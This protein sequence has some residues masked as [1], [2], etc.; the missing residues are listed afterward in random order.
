V[1]AD[2]DF[3]TG[4]RGVNL[5][6][7]DP[8]VAAALDVI[9]VALAAGG[10]H[11]GPLP[12]LAAATTCATV[13][14]RWRAPATMVIVA[15][16]SSAVF[17]VSSHGGYQE[18]AQVALLLDYYALGRLASQRGQPGVDV[19]LLAVPLAIVVAWGWNISRETGVGLWA[20]GTAVPYAVGR[21]VTS[22]AALS[23]QLQATARRLEREQQER[24]R[25][26]AA[27]ERNRIARELHD[28]VA[29]NVSVMV[30]QT[31]AAR[32]LAGRDRCSVGRAVLG[33]LLRSRRADGDAAD[34]WRAP[35]WRRGT[36]RGDG[37]RAVRARALVARARGAGLPVELRLEGEPRELAP[38]IDLMAFRI[39]Q[40][41]L[42]N[43]IKHAGPARARVIVVF[44]PHAVELEISDTGQGPAP[45]G[46]EADAHA[47]GH[48]LVGMRERVKLY[49]GQLET[50]QGPNG[51]FR[52]RA[53]VPLLE[54]VT[55]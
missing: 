7:V 14:W 41:A 36:R 12:L 20:L 40:E 10:T 44:A 38:D 34:D 28:V 30:I 22:Q 42:T 55:R 21:V 39:V 27:E 1:R 32:R 8:V 19:A 51:G 26:A 13:A 53:H 43:V 24:A 48:G 33:A 35:T 37:A 52:V 18:A 47:G 9:A 29:H 5:R 50:G 31:Q 3:S 46:A 2:G 25:R 54:L 49:G 17:A 15:V 23:A 16:A 11:H 45:T 4:A 6:G